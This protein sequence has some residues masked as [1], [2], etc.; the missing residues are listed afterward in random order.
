[1]KF[2]IAI[3]V[4][5]AGADVLW[6]AGFGEVF[7]DSTLRVD[8]VLGAG[9]GRPVA[10]VHS[11]GK[12]AG[13]AGRRG[14]LDELPYMGNGQL[15][16]RDAATDSVI[17]RSSFSTL[18]HE[19]LATDGVSDEARSF[20]HT[21]LMPLPRRK[22]VVELTLTD[23]RRDTLVSLSMPY[24]PDDVLVE[25]LERRELPYR[26]LHKGGDAAD[27]ID[28]AILAEGYTAGQ[29]DDF[30]GHTRRAVDEILAYE[31]FCRYK[32]K[33]N[34]V[35]VFSASPDEGVSVPHEGEW[36]RTSFGSH[37]TTFGMERYLTADGVWR[38]HSAAS[39]VPYEHLIV[40]ANT[41]EYGGGGIYNS[42]LLTAARNSGFR[43]VVVHEFGHSFGGLADEYFYEGDA[44]EDSYPHDVEPWEPNITT[45]VDFDSKWHGMLVAGTPVPTRP[46]DFGKYPVGVYEGGGYSA[47]GV[48]RPAYECRMR[49][50]SYPTFC[51]VCESALERLILFYTR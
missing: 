48:Y 42:Y 33:F 23:G 22:S 8:Y 5:C 43:P 9:G 34:F 18:F 20:E 3:F 36:R 24:S 12:M 38:M 45:L 46:A 14:R 11:V 19:W 50:N 25:K 40:L 44:L 6:A 47:K 37:F 26:Y 2:L 21:M 13:W 28:V 31:P 30:Y 49:N 4:I 16:V 17:Y 29:A 1:M 51:K 15:T 27:C 35:A 10:L 32:D 39:A 41:A 7:A